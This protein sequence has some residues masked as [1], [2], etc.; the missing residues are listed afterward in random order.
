MANKI[1]TMGNYRGEILESG[2]GVTQKS[3]FPQWVARLKALEKWV[4]SKSEMEHFKL[5]EP[6]WVDWSSFEEEILCYMVLFKSAEEFTKET[7]LLN[8]EQLQAATGWDGTEFDSLMTF[9][10]KKISFRVEDHEYEGKTSMQ[11]SWIDTWDADPVRKLRTLDT[12]EV[13]AL[14]KRLKIT[15]APA[16][17]A[18]KA[19]PA[20]PGKP[21]TSAAEPPATTAPA[22]DAPSGSTASAAPSKSP[23]SP[24]PESKKPSA[25]SSPDSSSPSTPASKSKSPP[26]KQTPPPPPPAK[27]ESADTSEL[28]RETT[29]I[30]AWN[31]ICEHKGD[32]EDGA[33]SDAW[34][35]ACGEIGGNRDEKDFTGADWAKVRDVVIKDLALT[36]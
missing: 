7:S 24:S 18:A 15:K 36:V 26:K 2:L 6:A 3:G 28:P 32:N 13:A 14:S 33:V 4:D 20:K 11:V 29:Q 27:E 31:F 10:G 35:A 25:T 21:A 1:D 17:A 9:A 16:A 22:A 34:L 8:Y 5:S 23:A 30:D 12:A 19:A